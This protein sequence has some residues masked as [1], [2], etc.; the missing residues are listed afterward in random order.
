MVAGLIQGWSRLGCTNSK[1]E[2]RIF[3]CDYC[4]GRY[5]EMRSVQSYKVNCWLGTQ[6]SYA[7]HKFPLCFHGYPLKTRMDVS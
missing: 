1:E 2:L 7:R 6:W 5:D 4:N 3:A